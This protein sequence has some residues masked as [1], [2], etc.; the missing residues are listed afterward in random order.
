MK[1]LNKEDRRRQLKIVLDGAERGTITRLAEHF[2][3]STG[4]IYQWLKEGG[5]WPPPKKEQRVWKFLGY[6][7]TEKGEITKAADIPTDRTSSITQAPEQF[8]AEQLYNA[9]TVISR[10]LT[11][12]AKSEDEN[13]T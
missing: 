1:R 12:R 2:E 11:R 4:L 13:R 3:T 10:E 9:L 7:L 6:Q 5:P 8:P